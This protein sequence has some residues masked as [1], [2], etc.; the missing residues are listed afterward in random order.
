VDNKIADLS[1]E[2]WNYLRIRI[3]QETHLNCWLDEFEKRDWI[4][5]D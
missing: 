3:Y 2:V 4:D 5:T 1:L